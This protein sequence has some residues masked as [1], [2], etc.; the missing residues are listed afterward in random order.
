[1]VNKMNE[2]NTKYTFWKLITE[3]SIEIPIMQRDYA[4]GR[5]SERTNSIRK[6]LLDSLL[7]SIDDDTNIDFDFVYGTVKDK[8]LL[9]LDGQ[10]RLTTLF[11]L[12]WYLAMKDGRLTKEVS[13]TLYKFSYSTR[14][15]SR[16]FCHELVNFKMDINE[17]TRVSEIIKDSNWY[18]QSW[19]KDPTIKAMLVMIDDIHYKFFSQENIFDK[20]IRDVDDNPP[21]TFSFIS[22]DDYSLTDNLYIKMNARGKSL[23]DFENFK[24]KFLQH[25]RHKGYDYDHFENSIDNKWTDFLWDYRSKDNTIDEAFIR[26]FTFISE[27]IFAEWSE[28]KDMYSPYRTFSI[29]TLIDTYDS[30]EKVQR[31]YEMMDLWSSKEEMF[32][33]MNSIFCREYTLGKTRLF[34]NNHNLMDVCLNGE[35][36]SF[37]NKVLLYMVMRRLLY[38]KKLGK[39]DNGIND[40]ARVIRNLVNRIRTLNV[41]TYQSD[42]RYGRHVIPFI[43]FITENL[44]HVDNVYEVLPT[45]TAPA[46]VRE[47]SLKDEKDK[48]G[49]INKSYDYKQRIQHLEDSDILRGSIHNF[50]NMLQESTEDYTDVIELMFSK[51][52]SGLAGRALLSICDYGIKIGMSALGERVY[53]GTIGNWNTVLTYKGDDSYKDIFSKLMYQYS[54]T[55]SNTVEDKLIEIINTNLKSIGKC[56]WRYY[57]A[58]YPNML[59]NYNMLYAFR[60]RSEDNLII[61]RMNGTTLNAYHIVTIYH[62]IALL[63]ENEICKANNCYGIN[64]DEGCICLNCGINVEIDESY[65]WI[66]SLNDSNI[67]KE[68]IEEVIDEFNDIDKSDKDYVEQGVILCTMLHNAVNNVAY[69]I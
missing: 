57:F 18:F 2:L 69:A 11:L 48:A 33:D 65:E 55:K 27:M 5:I 36:L 50:I 23:S 20:L 53:F 58:K 3:Y 10:Q 59:G 66:W 15:S 9:P 17:N 29:S 6:E 51:N 12:H 7:F 46:A 37:P 14:I 21:I 68:I 42:F 13:E 64:R 16:E 47:D 44:L 49:L 34:E 40:F 43:Q 56:K 35:N 38:Y 54:Q 60:K 41:Y 67:D 45:L 52:N 61:H 31:F 39:K 63:L 8:I 4:Q 62:E 22:L 32:D 25:L 30:N 28:A 1:M 24:A 19:D 26:I